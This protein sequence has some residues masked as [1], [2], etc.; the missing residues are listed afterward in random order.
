MTTIRPCCDGVVAAVANSEEQNLAL[1]HSL[2]IL[3]ICASTRLHFRIHQWPLITCSVSSNAYWDL[4]SESDLS[5]GRRPAVATDTLGL[6]RAGS[7]TV[8]GWFAARQMKHAH[9]RME[10]PP[11]LAIR[12]TTTIDDGWVTYAIGVLF[13]AAF[14][15]L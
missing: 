1:G 4:E 6:A 13:T 8:S 7:G 5:L 14:A 10:T 12:G 2:P 11:T 3:R 9:Q 15:D